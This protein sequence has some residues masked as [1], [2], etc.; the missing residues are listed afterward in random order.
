[1]ILSLN[2]SFPKTQK[3]PNKYSLK[4]FFLALGIHGIIFGCLYFFTE[5]FSGKPQIYFNENKK[6][7]Q[8]FI[9][10]TLENPLKKSVSKKPLQTLTDSFQGKMEDDSKV[11]SHS[12]VE[13]SQGTASH[14]SHVEA[15]AFEKNHS[16]EELFKEYTLHYEPPIYPRQAVERNYQG[17]VQLKITINQNAQVLAVEILQSSGHNIL[18]RAAVDSVAKWRFK[19]HTFA[20]NISLIKSIKFQLK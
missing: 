16:P 13:A 8:N 19:N 6:P 5:K 17:L 11:I 14:N 9:P 12:N 7:S 3:L 1:M 10:V 18:D 4:S 15:E 2:L 20:E